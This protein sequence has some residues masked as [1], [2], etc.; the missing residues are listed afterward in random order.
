MRVR[1]LI[2]LSV[3]GVIN[4]NKEPNVN[5]NSFFIALLDKDNNTKAISKAFGD[6]YVEQAPK[7]IE[8]LTLQNQ[9][10]YARYDDNYTLEINSEVGIMDSN[11]GGQVKVTFPDD[12]YMDVFNGVCQ[13]EDRFSLYSVCTQFYNTY[14]FNSANKAYDFKESGSLAFKINNHRNVEY[15]GYSGN[16]IVYNY[17]KNARA[18][19]ARSYGTLSTSYLKYSYDGLQL[20]VNGG[21]SYDLEVGSLS[22][23]IP[24][25]A[26]EAMK[27]RLIVNPLYFD[28]NFIFADTPVTLVPSTTGSTVRIAAPQTML[29]KKFYI[30]WQKT[31]DA[32]TKFYAPIPKFPVRIVKGTLTRSVVPSVT[33]YVNRGGISVP[34]YIDIANPPYD[35]VQVELQ[36]LG[37]EASKVEINNTKIAFGKADKRIYYLLSKIDDS[38]A[39]ATVTIQFSLTGTDA[40]SFALSTTS[41]NIPV[42]APDPDPAPFAEFRIIENNRGSVKIYVK[43]SK[44][45]YVYCAT[46]YMYM[47][48][49]TY[50]MVKGRN[51][52]EE[53]SYSKPLY[54]FGYVDTNLLEGTVLIDGLTP[55][56]EYTTYCYTMNLNGVP[57]ANFNK[58]TYKNKS[59][60]PSRRPAE[61]RH[62]HNEGQPRH[63]E[64]GAP[65]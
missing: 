19:L 49:P 60:L 63:R 18:V 58:L 25:G 26:I 40:T 6:V 39:G 32:L 3:Y 29:R 47:K 9:I 64:P 46:G 8:L 13:T 1:N 57:S 4:P 41:I 5:L 59:K 56:V 12:Y 50:S 62:L 21:N 16:I 22:D 48:E 17:D 30:T 35:L 20:L 51:L 23:P 10:P 65:R 42:N 55:S 52:T 24:V 15:E 44:L 27:Q 38:F 28:S 37:A 61:D 36:V 31:G 11:S 2:T 54:H 7:I 53:Y 43:S 14:E 34:L 33:L 45:A